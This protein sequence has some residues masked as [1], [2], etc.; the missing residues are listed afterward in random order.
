MCFSDVHIIVCVLVMYN[1]SRDAVPKFNKL[2]R[3]AQASLL[4]AARYRQLSA[5]WQEY[6]SNNYNTL[7]RHC[8]LYDYTCNNVCGSARALPGFSAISSPVSAIT[9]PQSSSVCILK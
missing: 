7:Q 5:I 1:F 2:A 8:N 9:V 3:C 6:Y 4:I